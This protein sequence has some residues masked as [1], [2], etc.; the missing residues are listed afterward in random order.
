[1]PSQ[2]NYKSCT[3]GKLSGKAF[4]R[5]IVSA[6]PNHKLVPHRKQTTSKFRE[7]MTLGLAQEPAWFT[8]QTDYPMT[9]IGRENHNNVMAS[10]NTVFICQET[11]ISTQELRRSCNM[12]KGPLSM[13]KNQKPNFPSGYLHTN[14]QVRSVYSFLWY[15]KL[16][17]SYHPNF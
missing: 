3:R 17:P 15:F 12:R 9:N 7:R 11:A 13:G 2:Q 14:S 10:P 6:F 8:C 1:L 5:S 4:H 16:G